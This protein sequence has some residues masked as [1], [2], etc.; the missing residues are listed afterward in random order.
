M[1]KVIM[2]ESGPFHTPLP[3]LPKYNKL[4]DHGID[5]N[6]HWLTCQSLAY[7]KG[8]RVSSLQGDQFWLANFNI[9]F[10][11]WNVRAWNKFYNLF[12]FFLWVT[13]KCVVTWKQGSWF[14]QCKR[15]HLRVITC[16]ICFQ[17]KEMWSNC[18]HCCLAEE[19]Y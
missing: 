8:S 1:K 18:D 16:T 13:T 7:R 17:L 4:V 3:H 12:G 15:G 19:G 9:F 14:F 11:F 10:C 5:N 6:T 2:I